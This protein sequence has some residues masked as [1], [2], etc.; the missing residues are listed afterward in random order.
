MQTSAYPNYKNTSPGFTL[1][2]ILVVLLIVTILAGLT[3]T[4]LPSFARSADFD[5]EVRRIELLFSMARTEAILDSSEFGFRLS[6][7]GY[8]FSKFD[9]ASQSWRDAASPFQLRELPSEF[10]LTIRSDNDDFRLAG[11]N[12]PPILILSS[13]ETTPF[14]LILESTIDS[15]TRIFS[16]DGYGQF[17]WRDDD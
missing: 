10:R 8:K 5:T 14:D 1:V 2:E 4:R 15:E 11:E 3:V 16:A 12:L 17:K 6:D 7:T 9:H 13:G